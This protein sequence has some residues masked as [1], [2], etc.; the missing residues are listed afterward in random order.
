MDFLVRGFV[1]NQIW[2]EVWFVGKKNHIWMRKMLGCGGNSWF[3]EEDLGREMRE[4]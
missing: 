1:E 3:L 4:S 2:M